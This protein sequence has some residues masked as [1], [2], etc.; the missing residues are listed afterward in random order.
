[1]PA[2][3]FAIGTPAFSRLS[4][5]PQTVAMDEDPLDSRISETSRMVYGND[6]L[7]GSTLSSARSARWPW[8]ISRRPGAPMR[9]VSP[10]ENGGKL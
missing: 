1:M 7:L 9:P 8:P 3:D 2:T 4:V 10:T 6:S 5:P